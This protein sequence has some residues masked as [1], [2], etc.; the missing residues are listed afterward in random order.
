Y[1]RT[2]N[3]SQEEIDKIMDEMDE[4]S[5]THPYGQAMRL[6]SWLDTDRDE[7]AY[8]EIRKL[9]KRFPDDQPLGALYSS[10]CVDH[11]DYEE[12]RSTTEHL[13]E[14]YPTNITLQ[15]NYGEC[16]VH[17]GKIEEAKKGIFKL[18]DTLPVGS[19]QVV[20]LLNVIKE[21]NEKLISQL[22]EENSEDPMKQMDLGWCYLQND[23]YEDALA[24]CEK[25]KEDELE[26]KYVYHNLTSKVLLSL[27]KT[28]EA[29][30][31]LEWICAYLPTLEEDGTEDTATRIKRYPEFVQYVGEILWSQKK[32]DEGRAKLKE[33]AELMPDNSGILINLS[34]ILF[35]MNDNH[36][37]LAYAEDALSK[38]VN[39]P[40]AHYWYAKCL[41]SLRR[42]RE[43]FDE[44]NIALNLDPSQLPY[45]ELK[46]NIL[47]SNQAWDAVHELMDFLKGA[48]ADQLAGYHY[49]EGQIEELENKNKDEALKIY[50]E[51]AERIEAGEFMDDQDRLYHRIASLEGDSRDLKKNKEDFDLVLSYVNKALDFNEHDIPTL[52]YQAWMYRQIKDYDK[53]LEIYRKLEAYPTHS[54]SIERSIAEVLYQNLGKNGAECLKYFEKLR[55]MYPEDDINYFYLGTTYRY[56]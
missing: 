43:A 53:S 20:N 21:W 7:L 19:P 39:S 29:L 55:D 41:Y 35:Q 4:L 5:E 27:N 37:A 12:A 25:I 26:D 42:D 32:L 28:E 14:F 50:H 13:L 24:I 45:Y 18:I 46:M 48:G 56:M 15:M 31:H 40:L 38:D 3:V 10:V 2:N 6:R 1:N 16:L 49:F 36:A 22:I 47:I 17:E 33:A 44:V 51:V 23:R 30:P 8:S 34:R 9:A 52:Y 11:E 54:I